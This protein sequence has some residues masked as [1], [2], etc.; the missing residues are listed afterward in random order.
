MSNHN[1]TPHIISTEAKGLYTLV[2]VDGKVV[3]GYAPQSGVKIITKEGLPFK[4]F[5][6]T[7]QLVPYE[8]WRLPAE[9][10][11]ADLAH[12]L[13]IEEIAGLMLYSPQNK[14]PM[15]D[16]T[17][18]YNGQPFTQSGC[19][20]DALSDGQRRFLTA[21]KVRHVLVSKV[22]DPA[23]AAQWSNRVQAL[24]EGEGHGIPANNSSDPRHSATADAEFAAGAGGQ[25]SLW[26]SMLGLAATF[27][28]HEVE[29]FARIAAHEYRLLGITTALSPQADLG[30]DPRWYRFSSTFGSDP[31]L[32]ADLTR[33]YS[34]GF[35]SP[36]RGNWS[37]QSVNTMAKHW[38]GGGSGEGGRDAHYGNGKFAV[39]PGGC[40]QQHKL[41]FLKGAFALNGKTGSCSAIMPYYTISYNQTSENVG[42]GFNHDILT[43]Q[44]RGEAGF[45]GVICTDWLIT[46]DEVH[47]GTHSG[48]PWGVE[49][50]TEAQRH[51]KALMAGVDQFGG[52][53]DIGPVLEA[54]RMGVA[55]H[56]EAW[57]RQRFEQSAERLLLNIFRVG[58][59]DNPYI[60]V[61]EA[62]RTVGSAQYMSEGYHRHAE[63][64]S[65]AV[66][67]ATRHTRVHTP[68][69]RARRARLLAQPSALSHLPPRAAQ[70]LAA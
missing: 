57:M 59:F 19:Q 1:A 17:D 24:V 51:Y 56:G 11:A 10:R 54:Y 16:G 6:R 64:P 46:H 63:E 2:K 69:P 20:A 32:V 30:T 45:K 62:A 47:P 61:D 13:S 66:T 60:D 22:K 52:N 67:A 38:P 14:L 49:T 25:I 35:Q 15:P 55:E 29:H 5:M 7:G 27:S 68:A 37:A 58:L 48:K 8:D 42:N 53:Q 39:Y 65:G 26:S 40:Y 33:A 43:Q 4:D 23:T 28:P 21:D 50:L 70:Y 31:Q 12:R 34:D 18:T 41:P 36:D 3:L 44:L 9:E